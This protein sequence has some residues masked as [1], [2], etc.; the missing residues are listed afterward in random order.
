MIKTIIFDM[1]GVIIT[2]DS[3]EAMKRFKGLGLKDAEKILDPYCQS[4]VFGDLEE[5]KVSEEEYHQALENMVGRKLTF[6]EIQHCWLGYM[7][8]VPALKL[9]AIRKL[10]DEGYRVV[11][12]SNTNPYVTKWTDSKEFSGDGHSIGEY[13]DAMYRSYEV[14]YMKP[15][16]NFFRY[17]LSEEKILPEEVLF[18]DDGPRN[19][20]AASELG[21]RTYCPANGADWTDEIYEYLK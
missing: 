9:E 13:F 16:E 3:N 19:C 10:K 7:V 15:D 11:L 2:L 20:A 18:V 6:Q 14:K 21:I 1:G 17:V 12:L 5:G 8:D 4:G